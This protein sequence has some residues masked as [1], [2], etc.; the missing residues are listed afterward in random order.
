MITLYF[1][2]N[3][4]QYMEKEEIQ[5][6]KISPKAM[7]YGKIRNIPIF[8][9]EFSQLVKQEK[10]STLFHTKK[11]RIILPLHYEEIDKE[12]LT[13]ILNNNN[14]KQITFQ[15]EINLFQLKKNQI[16]VNLNETYLTLIKK[17]KR[18]TEILFFPT[19]IFQSTENMLKHIIENNSEKSRFYFLGSNKN[20]S[21][22]ITKINN[23]RLFY[24]QNASQH[25]I[26]KL[27]P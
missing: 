15:K 2:E 19:N 11:I 20:I 1:Y 6:Y 23:N 3:I 7:K 13:S 18:K 8:E 24:F 26:Q 17:A 5:E 4:I 21:K 10:W 14:I 16:I 9:E 22:L 12:I 25:I 27:I